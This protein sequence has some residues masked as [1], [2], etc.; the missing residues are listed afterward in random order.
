MSST[1]LLSLALLT[2]L[3]AVAVVLHYEGLILLARRFRRFTSHR[4]ALLTTMFGLLALHVIEIW[5]FAGGYWFGIH[6]L[7][8]GAITPEL[9]D[10]LDAVYFSAMVY[11]TVGFGD[12]VP[13]G[14]L[15]LIVSGEALLGLS[16]I[17]WSASFTFLQMQSLWRDD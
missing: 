11:T 8:L 1:S 13:S 9:V 14:A 5:V 15:R 12:L 17:T 4:L 6:T 7:G 16:L 3:V 2:A 10:Y